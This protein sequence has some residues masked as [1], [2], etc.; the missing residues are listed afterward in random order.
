MEKKAIASANQWF[1]PGLRGLAK[2]H[3]AMASWDEDAITMSVEAARACLDGI[4][5]SRVDSLLFA[6]TTAPFADRLNASVI[7][8]ALTLGD[9]LGAEDIGGSQK[10]GATAL[11]SGLRAI[12]AADSDCALVTASE[13]RAA[14]VASVQEL[15]FGDGAAAIL[16]GSGDDVLAEL[17]GS[18]SVT[19]DFVDHFREAHEKYDYRWEERWIRDE[20]LAKIAPKAI[21]GALEK[22]GLTGGDIDA[23][24]MASAMRGAPGKIAKICGISADNVRDTLGG[25]SGDLGVAHPL[26]MLAHALDEAEPGQNILVA[27][28]GQGC[29]ALIF[30]TTERLR[31]VA[32]RA[33]SISMLNAGVNEDNY[34]KFL[35][36]KGMLDI[37]KGMRAE[38]DAKT[39]LTTLY[40]KRDML[41]GLVGGQCTECGSAQFPRT[42]T[43]ANPNCEAVDSQEPYPFA[44]KE[45]EVLSWSADYLAYT[46]DPPQHYGTLVFDGGG[47]FMADI[48]DVEQGTIDSGS[49]MRMVFRIKGFDEKRGFRKYFWKATPVIENN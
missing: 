8:S 41:T 47:R 22:A 30:R 49:R 4:D 7:A 6:S 21:K 16:L 39:A 48:T 1:N 25:K 28:F 32:G 44:E 12:K 34:L 18:N 24:V 19:A 15:Q 27:G 37:D 42:R 35:T 2:G 45:A 11:L 23:F 10:A 3:R 38:Q 46:P 43:C 20:G 14:R 5:R 31:E 13:M 36:F 9:E 40:R 33:Q 26:F 29:D 17:I